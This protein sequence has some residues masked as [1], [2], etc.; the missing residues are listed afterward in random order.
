MGRS[1]ASGSLGVARESEKELMALRKIHNTYYVYYRDVD[2]KLKTRSLKTTD[3]KL[4]QRLHDDYILQLQ[5][6]KG[7]AVIMRDFPELKLPPELPK[8]AT[9]EHQ[10]G[11]IRLGRMIDELNRIR[12]LSGTDQLIIS[13]II[14]AMPVKYVDQVTPELAL[15]YLEKN[16]SDGRNYKAFNNN[17]C[18]LHK[19]FSLLLVHAKMKESPFERI[20]CRKVDNVQSHRPL[21]NDEFK[22]LFKAATE[23]YKTILALG[24]YAGADMSTAFAI[25]CQA[26]NLSERLIRWKRPK[27][28]IW[29]TCGIQAELLQILSTANFPADSERPFVSYIKKVSRTSANIYFRELFEQ[30]NIKD[31]SEGKASFH[32]LRASF[33][34]RCDEAKLHPRTTKLAGGH[35]SEAMN[36][37]Y[38]HDVSAA[39]EV[40]NL[41]SVGLFE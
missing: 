2:G 16:Y 11:G 40:E 39:H 1:E 10:R 37:L 19:A 8:P 27:S 38:S 4:A 33:F 29:F 17:R 15:S 12:P 9:G 7:R 6:Q 22:T 35:L 24:F 36:D 41:P 30:C 3:A 5:A 32:S 18:V 31:N 25:P 20:V 14:E 34:T 23:P 28:G 26:I 13:R 21:T